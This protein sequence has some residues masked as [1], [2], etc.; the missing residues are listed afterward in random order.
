MCWSHK[1]SLRLTLMRAGHAIDPASPLCIMLSSHTRPSTPTPRQR[2]PRRSLN[3]FIYNYK[4]FFRLLLPALPPP[5]N[6]FSV[7]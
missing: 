7:I 3:F 5:H 4:S 1:G 2:N 6:V